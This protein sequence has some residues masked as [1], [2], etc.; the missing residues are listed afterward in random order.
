MVPY[1]P[2]PVI[3]GQEMTWGPPKILQVVSWW[4]TWKW[5]V[6]SMNEVNFY[7]NNCCFHNIF[8]GPSLIG[9]QLLSWSFLEQDLNIFSYMLG[10]YLLTSH[11]G[12]PNGALLFSCSVGP[13]RG[14]FRCLRTL[15]EGWRHLDDVANV[16]K[17]FSNFAGKTGVQRLF[18]CFAYIVFRVVISC[19][20]QNLV[21]YV[22]I[23]ERWTHL[24]HL[25]WRRNSNVKKDW[26]KQRPGKVGRYWR[27][28]EIPTRCFDR[29]I[30]YI[31]ILKCYSC[32]FPPSEER[33]TCFQSFEGFCWNIHGSDWI[34][35]NWM[36]PTFD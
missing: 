20:S 35:V 30:I 23:S 19:Q 17:F 18:F 1:Q 14:C 22:L 29:E 13:N 24:T 21:F 16:G 11:V 9:S 31:L 2:I 25:T 36:L 8:R 27:H 7:I 6:M 4:L 33:L 32:L 15:W 12:F 28:H 10:G 34:G 26:C 5:W 3:L